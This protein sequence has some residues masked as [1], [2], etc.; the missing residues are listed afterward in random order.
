MIVF[1]AGDLKHRIFVASDQHD[2]INELR[3]LR[4]HWQF[5]QLDSH[6]DRSIY[7]H[8]QSTFNRLPSHTKLE[9]TR[10]LLVELEILSRVNYVVC[11][12]SSNICRFVQIIRNQ[13]PD[14]V[15]SLDEE[16]H[17]Q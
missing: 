14:T 5:V 4:P 3:Y 17:N 6:V 13:K 8:K 11:T 12:F 10:H 7:G 1:L 16:W 2:V 9:C 15:L